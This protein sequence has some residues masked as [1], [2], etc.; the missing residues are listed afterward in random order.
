M[1][2][3]K[4]N[5]ATAQFELLNKVE[6]HAAPYVVSSFNTASGRYVI[7]G[8]HPLFIDPVGISLTP[9]QALLLAEQIIHNTRALVQAAT[10]LRAQ[11][12]AERA[13]QVVP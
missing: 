3:H 11:L 13:A 9:S 7:A 8:Q 6:P 10:E 1:G 5:P 12:A 2:E 4:Q